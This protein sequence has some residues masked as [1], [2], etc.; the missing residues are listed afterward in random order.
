MKKYV[1]ILP[2]VIIAGPLLIAFARGTKPSVPE[3]I[4]LARQL[5]AERDALGALPKARVSGSPHDFGI[6]DPLTVG[7]HDFVIR[8]DG[9]APLK[10]EAGSTTCKCTLG[11]IAKPIIPPG[12]TSVVRLT[13]NTGRKHKIYAHSATIRTNDPFK[14]TIDLKIN[15]IVRV[16]LGSIPNEFV[17]P[18]VEPD[19]PATTTGVVYSQIWGEFAV[20]EVTCSIDGATWEIEPVDCETLESLEAK[21]GY[22]V[23]VTVPKGLPSGH[24]N[25]QLHLKVLPSGKKK[26]ES[27]DLTLSGRVIRRLAVYGPGVE[28]T[29]TID[30][31]ILRPRERLKRRLMMK[32]RDDQ[33]ELTV[34]RIET[35]PDFLQVNVTPQDADNRANGLYYLDI[36]IPEDA[37]ECAYRGSKLGQICL[38]IDHP[39]IEDLALKA[40]FAIVADNRTL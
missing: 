27:L 8:N 10:L 30:L 23:T 12:G 33:P 13:W 39:R 25:D 38:A 22:H 32:V 7:T 4:L 37:P 1:V 31:G 28:T 18:Q 2:V 16:Q 19:K 34:G 26:P 6:M 14:R 15:G 36:V 9:D 17:L 20:K 29:G 35:T 11:K 3:G 24:F 21:S 5:R 40:R